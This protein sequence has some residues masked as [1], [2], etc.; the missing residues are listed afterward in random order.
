M[1]PEIILAIVSIGISPFARRRLNSV[2]QAL[3]NLNLIKYGGDLA[4]GAMGIVNSVVF[5][6]SPVSLP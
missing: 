2:V 1:Q 5:S 4:V 6:S 3:L